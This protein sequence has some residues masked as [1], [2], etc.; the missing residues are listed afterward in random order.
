MLT[1]SLIRSNVCKFSLG[2]RPE[3]VS[4]GHGEGGQ[5]M[6]T[7]RRHKLFVRIRQNAAEDW[8]RACDKALGL[9]CC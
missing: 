3:S 6:T 9:P 8:R 1:R 5:D 7:L 4:E 2:K